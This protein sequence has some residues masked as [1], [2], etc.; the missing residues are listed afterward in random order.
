MSFAES[1]DRNS[2]ILSRTIGLF[3]LE[4]DLV[5]IFGKRK[6]KD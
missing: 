1:L 5:L 3:R 6:L 2:K 4:V